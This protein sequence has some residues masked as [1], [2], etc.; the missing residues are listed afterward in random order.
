MVGENGDE[1]EAMKR[2]QSTGGRV[3]GV[4]DTSGQGWVGTFL[5]L[6]NFDPETVSEDYEEA[7]EDE[8]EEKIAFSR[9]FKFTAPPM[10]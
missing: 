8:V 10:F 4:M 9:L 1:E 5:Q 3:D 6:E 7:V 2:K